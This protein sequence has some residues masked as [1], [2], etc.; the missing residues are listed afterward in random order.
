M[1]IY[2]SGYARYVYSE[3]SEYSYVSQ[4]Q[5]QFLEDPLINGMILSVRLDNTL[6][7]KT[8]MTYLTRGLWLAPRYAVN[9]I[10]EQC[11]Y[12]NL[13]FHK[14]FHILILA[15]TLQA[16]A[17]IHNE[18][19]RSYDITHSQLITGNVS[20]ITSSPTVTPVVQYASTADAASPISSKADATNFGTYSYNITRK[21]KLYPKS[22]ETYPFL[23]PTIIFNYTLEA[24]TYISSGTNF[25]LFQRV[26]VLQASE[27]LPAG[28]ATFYLQKTGTCL[29]QG[30]LIDAAKNSKQKFYLGTD[31]DVKY[32]IESTIN[33]RK[34][35]PF[36]ADAYVY[37]VFSNQ[38]V[39]QT[40]TV[41]LT[42]NSGLVDTKLTIN[43]R[44]SSSITISQ[45]PTN[46]SMLIVRGIIK[47]NE[48]ASCS[49][50]FRK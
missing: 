45:D 6:I 5:I 12:R 4:E 41:T 17:D 8:N 14:R 46:K 38:K 28:I 40:V 19:E 20:L 3:Y 36:Q 37:V 35:N 29:G 32:A 1:F 25:G 7:S 39:K 30:R 44:S 50:D 33:T 48:E 47:P 11:N 27:F 42:I 23:T 13:L 15:A 18:H 10:N 16:L 2:Y 9:I 43:N 21:F 31:P 49:F 24:T 22:I 34:S 26:F